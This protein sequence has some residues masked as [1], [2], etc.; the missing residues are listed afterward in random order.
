MSNTPATKK[1]TAGS[2]GL[3]AIHAES[4]S[5]CKQPKRRADMSLESQVDA[6]IRDNLRGWDRELVETV[7]VEGMWGLRKIETS[8]QISLS[9]ASIATFWRLSHLM[10]DSDVIQI[11]GRLHA[12]LSQSRLCYCGFA[13][14]RVK[15]EKTSCG[16]FVDLC[17]LSQERE[18]SFLWRGLFCGVQQLSV[19]P[20]QGWT[21][22]DYIRKMREDYNAGRIGKPGCLWW[23]THKAM[24]ASAKSAACEEALSVEADPAPEPAWSLFLGLLEVR[25]R[26]EPLQQWA[27]TLVAANRDEFVMLAKSL[28]L[29][30][31]S[32]DLVHYHCCL[33]IL[34]SIQRLR[35]HEEH[36][37]VFGAIAQ[38][39]DA[40]ML[41]VLLK[42]CTL[43]LCE[44]WKYFSRDGSTPS[45]FVT[46]Y[47][48]CIW[49]CL[50]KAETKRVMERK[51]DEDMT[52]VKADIEACWSW[53]E[54]GKALFDTAI[55]KVSAESVQKVIEEE[56][57]SLISSGKAVTEVELCGVL[58]RLHIKLDS[59]CGS[60]SLEGKRELTLKYRGMNV[61]M[62]VKSLKEEA[63]LRLR[64]AIREAGV[65]ASKLVPL[66]GENALL[67]GTRTSLQV[68]STVVSKAN[69]A[70]KHFQKCLDLEDQI[71]L[72]KYRSRRQIEKYITQHG[73]ERI[74]QLGVLLMLLLVVTNCLTTEPL[75]LIRNSLDGEPSRSKLGEWT[76]RNTRVCSLIPQLSG[77]SKMAVLKAH[78]KDLTGKDAYWALDI[79]IVTSMVNVQG[80][81]FLKS[82]A[83]SSLSRHS[84]D[85]SVAL[86]ELT[87][88]LA[89]DNIRWTTEAVKSELSSCKDLLQR[90]VDGQP[91]MSTKAH[92]T[93]WLT[94]F[95]KTLEQYCSYTKEEKVEASVT[96]GENGEEIKQEATTR[97]VKL[98]GAVA[99]AE[100]IERLSAN[101]ATS[102]EEMRDL[103]IWGHLLNDEQKQLVSTL[104]NDLVAKG[105]QAVPKPETSKPTKRS[106]PAVDKQKEGLE[107]AARALLK[108]RPKGATASV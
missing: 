49:L 83:M 102:M 104:R 12:N 38:R 37:C 29:M 69:A 103:A 99:L 106:T 64:L 31:P 17:K 44:A 15:P 53:G 73:A 32:L 84:T 26:I 92:T 21:F 24:F 72:V 93:P 107:K 40:T 35:L 54:L 7:T 5:T 42:Q 20:V 81:E 58:G 51:W 52:T 66:A 43:P 9:V 30:K 10:L 77:G 70:R 23:K 96:K 8:V 57:K 50:P 6:L 39:C 45:A 74:N 56:L 105:V 100:L 91:V 95:L 13:A 97:M 63:N 79:A 36:K 19:F 46:E 22:R 86:Q 60:Q 18:C 98:S 90:L 55:A 108:M 11:S 1:R 25:P 3:D 61:P 78:H 89:D 2:S 67:P 71:P 59:L 80:A 28:L 47:D 75:L 85:A 88:S 76:I 68:D 62:V 87:K 33:D 101:G 14:V 27:Y 48:D 34:R 4:K 82:T 94:N 16:Q 65:Q 41:Q